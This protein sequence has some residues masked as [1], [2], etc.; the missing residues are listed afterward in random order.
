MKIPPYN[1]I[2]ATENVDVNKKRKICT[3]IAHNLPFCRLFFCLIRGTG[4]AVV[5]NDADF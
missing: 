2:I 3:H 4:V 1:V 5:K